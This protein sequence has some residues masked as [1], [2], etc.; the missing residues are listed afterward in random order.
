MLRSAVPKLN[1]HIELEHWDRTSKV[2]HNRELLVIQGSN[3]GRKML[4]QVPDNEQ[5]NILS[6]GRAVSR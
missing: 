3:A 2:G 5:N 6:H 4:E 1:L